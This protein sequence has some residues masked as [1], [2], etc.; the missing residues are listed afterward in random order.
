MAK[1]RSPIHG[2]AA[3]SRSVSVISATITKANQFSPR[4]S[5]ETPPDME[6]TD[7]M[8]TQLII[9]PRLLTSPTASA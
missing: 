6:A 2:Q 5:S 9:A 3:M 7:Q 1:N 4:V 8:M